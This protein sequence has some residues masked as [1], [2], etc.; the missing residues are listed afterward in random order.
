MD[1]GK[2]STKA[3]ARYTEGTLLRAMSKISETVDDPVMKKKLEECKG[4]GTP[5]T[6]AGIIE[7]LKKDGYLNAVAG[8]LISS[9]GAR[10]FIKGLPRDM[11]D[12]TLTARWESA[13]DRIEARTLTLDQFMTKQSEWI[14]KITRIAMETKIS[15]SLDK[16]APASEIQAAGAGLLCGVCK[17]G[18]MTPRKALKGANAGN[19]FLGCSCYP[20]CKNTQNVDAKS[21][22]KSA[23]KR[24]PSGAARGKGGSTGYVRK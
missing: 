23:P 8:K 19:Y 12:A 4:I 22:V 5:A 16:K 10:D 20:E 1:P 2:K 11:T 17:T 6:Q 15:I 3:P 24:P 7:K 18:T 14:T 21:A 9:Q 13:L